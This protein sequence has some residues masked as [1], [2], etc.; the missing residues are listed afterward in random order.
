MKILK[1]RCQGGVKK[2]TAD[3]K[4]LVLVPHRDA[5]RRLREWSRVLFSAGCEGA[6]S[7]PWVSPLAVLALPL[8]TEELKHCAA[9]LREASLADGR[10]GKFKCGAAA[11]AAFPPNAPGSGEAAVFG[12][13]L[14]L[15][16]PEN[17]FTAGAAE[18]ILYRFSLPVLGSSLAQGDAFRRSGT[19]EAAFPPV[20]A[21]SFRAAAL[22]NMSYRSL[23]TADDGA[24]SGCS[25]EWRIG[26]LCWLPPVKKRGRHG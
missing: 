5:R 21:I 16:V 3:L 26:R 14:D 11:C 22:A 25:F 13:L 19:M 12:P 1:T 9:V 7:F 6:W 24:G 10:D 4:L 17:T 2:N 15:A 20:P 8:N 18:K 23:R